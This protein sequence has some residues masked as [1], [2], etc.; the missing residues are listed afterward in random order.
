[1]IFGVV[2]WYVKATEVFPILRK[3]GRIGVKVKRGRT[4]SDA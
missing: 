3:P 1:M 2:I 4:G